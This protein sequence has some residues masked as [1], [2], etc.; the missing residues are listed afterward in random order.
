M[1]LHLYAPEG[2][3]KRGLASFKEKGP[4][5]EK[6]QRTI[7]KT[8]A[9]KERFSIALFAFRFP[10]SVYRGETGNEGKR[11]GKRNGSSLGRIGKRSSLRV[12]GNERIKKQISFP[13]GY[14]AIFRL[15]AH[16]S[17]GPSL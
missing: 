3:K 13:L 2:N 12:E 17:R 4:T 10:F 7:R 11:T 6:C 15:R 16:S 14:T 5:T 8:H 9:R 1:A